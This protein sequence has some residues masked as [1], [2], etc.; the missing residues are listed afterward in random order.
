[1]EILLDPWTPEKALER[2]EEC[3]NLLIGGDYRVCGPHI[4][5]CA[6][7]EVDTL[8]ARCMRDRLY[9]VTVP[10]LFAKY[11]D[12]YDESGE[13]LSRIF[14][15]L[16]RI[17]SEVGFERVT[18]CGHQILQKRAQAR[19]RAR[20]DVYRE[21]LMAAVWHPARFPDWCLDTQERDALMVL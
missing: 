1:M 6:V 19:A 16:P 9:H 13:V 3:L 14:W 7:K 11:F 20:L 5:M 18:A 8:C 17:F 4:Q 15:Y 12:T 10:E 2:V 21:E